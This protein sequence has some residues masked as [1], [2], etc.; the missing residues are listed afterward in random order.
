M[1]QLL[2]ALADEDTPMV[3]TSN[4]KC[5]ESDRS[6]GRRLLEKTPRLFIAY[7]ALVRCLKEQADFFDAE[8]SVLIVK[9]PSNWTLE[10]FE[11]VAGVCLGNT[12]TMPETY[13]AYSHPTRNRKGKWD[14]D[15]QNQLSVPKVLVFV[16]DGAEVH[17]QFLTAA[18]AC[19]VLCKSAPRAEKA[20]AH[21]E[22][23]LAAHH[24]TLHAK[25]TG[26]T[27]FESGFEFLGH[28]FVRSL[29]MK[30]E[31]P[32]P[33]AKPARSHAE[34]EPLPPQRAI[35]TTAQ[36]QT[37]LDEVDNRY[38]KGGITAHIHSDG[39]RLALRNESYS[40]E[41]DLG[42]EITAISPNRV[43]HI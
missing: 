24:L 19:L 14:F 37:T 15:P 23:V 9:V 29:A 42:E 26:L 5:V 41:N 30:K 2:N 7:C 13:N 32:E 21:I 16:R 34:P 4:K 39:R 33:V 6:A 18:N 8:S 43:S 35:E 28:L 12:K 20:L 25:K 31:T 11:H 38:D 17:P 36:M 10:D 40:V 27:S 22:K 1:D 3:A